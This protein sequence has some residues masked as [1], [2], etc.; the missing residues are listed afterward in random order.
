MSENKTTA[1][2]PQERTGMKALSYELASDK[3]KKRFQEMLGKKAPGFLASISSVVAN[4]ALLQKA[5]V[6]SIT[7]AAAQAAALDLPI[8]PNI[9]YAAI[10][11]YKGAATLQVM[12]NGYVELALRS[13]QV[14]AIENELVYEGELVK[15]DRFRGEYEFDESQRKSDKIIGAMAYI[16]LA[17]G[18]EK[19]VYWSR[20][21]C[22]EH[23]KKYSK[24]FGGDNSL[25]TTNPEAMMLKTVLKNLIVK[26]IPKSIEMFMAINNDG[27]HFTGDIDNPEATFDDA[28]DVSSEVVEINPDEIPEAE[29]PKEEIKEQAKVE[30]EDF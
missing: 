6:G 4:N 10:V 21:K 30:E 29:T 14:V 27:A 26:Y 24:T 25:W 5:D 20:E 13:G 28:V 9:G 2:A 23:G 15:A 16:K 22:M 7:L 17:N 12:R 11:P 18:F 3:I 1:V 19:T 8:N